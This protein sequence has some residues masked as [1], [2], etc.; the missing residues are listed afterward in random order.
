MAIFLASKKSM[1]I[2]CN[3]NFRK[4]S[5]GHLKGSKLDTS[6]VDLK[7]DF[8]E[9]LKVKLLEW[10][11]IP[12]ILHRHNMKFSKN[13]AQVVKIS[14]TEIARYISDQENNQ[15]SLPETKITTTFNCLENVVGK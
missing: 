5:S 6:F 1:K 11:R 7:I 13:T 14:I 12:Y 9:F 15:N 8:K 3:G 4:S 2:R 10:C